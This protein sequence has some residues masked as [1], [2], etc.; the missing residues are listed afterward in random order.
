MAS[1]SPEAKAFYKPRLTNVDI[2]LL[3]LVCGPLWGVQIV[4]DLLVIVSPIAA[5][6]GFVATAIL[7]IFY[8][9]KDVYK[10]KKN[11][12]MKLGATL[13]TFG[14]EV[15]PELDLIPGDLIELII[16]TVITRKEDREAAEAKAAAATK[17]AQEAQQ[18]RIIQYNNFMQQRYLQQQSEIATANDTAANDNESDAEEEEGEEDYLEAT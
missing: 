17:A 10:T 15:I 16:L 1:M 9:M 11:S 3:V 5:F 13:A 14:I 4:M 6:L 2:L 8:Y 12:G 18:I 7:T